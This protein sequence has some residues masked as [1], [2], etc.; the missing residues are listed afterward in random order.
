MSE[1]KKNS[2]PCILAFAPGT[3]RWPEVC[4]STRYHLWTLAGMGWRVL[5]V[6]PPVKFHTIGK[7][8]KAPDRDFVVLTPG[9]IMPFGVRGI[10]NDQMAEKW[11]SV[12][13]S[14]L[15]SR[16]Q[17]ALKSLKWSPHV[18]WFGAPW[19]SEIIQHLPPGP[20]P[21]THVYDDLSQSPI[22]NA[23]QRE[24]LW[25]WER[26]LLRACN[27]ALCSS[28]PQM[29]KRE[30]I[31][32][33]T[34][35]LENAVKDSFIYQFKP[36]DLDEKTRKIA[37]RIDRLTPPRFVYGGVADL[38]LEPEFF[39]TILENL[40]TGNVIF[41]GR[42]EDSLDP[43]LAA[44]IEGN[45]RMHCLGEIPYSSYPGLYRMADVLL[46][47]HKRMPFTDAMFPEKLI[48]YLATGRPVVSVGLPE[49]GR[50][51]REAPYE[52]ILRVADSP[53]EYLAAATVAMNDKDEIHEEKRVEIARN[54]TWSVAGE[55]AHRELLE[56]VTRRA[57]E[58]QQGKV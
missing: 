51:A 14:Q 15:A 44:D 9:R 5:Y 56:E 20:V 21:V 3:W 58:L 33:R 42:K 48:E 52:G 40:P 34:F 37:A 30:D 57:K 27:V 25:R 39:R 50:I 2:G 23:M 49:V 29:E 12:T 45:P 28:M 16:A 4:G 18:Y 17:R 32:R 19:H 53:W 24:I 11:R 1:Q 54:H 38:R 7:T 31:A 36:Y 22:F 10:K 13:S 47:P 55:R 6:E 41:L 46:I 26:E 35:L 8:W 43:A